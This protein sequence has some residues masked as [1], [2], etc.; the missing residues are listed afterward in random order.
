V[1]THALISL[2]T[3]KKFQRMIYRAYKYSNRYSVRL[4]I[5]YCRFAHDFCRK[6]WIYVENL[7]VIATDEN[8]AVLNIAAVA[9]CGGLEIW[10]FFFLVTTPW[11][12]KKNEN[13]SSILR[14]APV[15]FEGCQHLEGYV[16]KYPPRYIL[17]LNLFLLLWQHL[18]N[19]AVQPI[20][21]ES[22]TRNSLPLCCA[23]SLIDEPGFF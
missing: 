1:Q 8:S 18:P 11:R 13:R 23:P 16:I 7:P 2:Q 15:G 21:N 4:P 9:S 5:Y 6:S 10:S 14:T 20:V 17:T 22:S 3:K 12:R 19:V